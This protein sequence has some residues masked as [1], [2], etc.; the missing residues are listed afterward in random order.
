MGENLAGTERSDMPRYLAQSDFGTF[1]FQSGRIMAMFQSVGMT[2]YFQMSV[3]RGS[4]QL[5]IGA[6]PD[7]RSSAVMPQIPGARVVFSFPIAADIS[8]AV[9]VVE[10]NDGSGDALAASAMR[11][12]SSGGAGLLNCSWKWSFHLWSWSCFIAERCSVFGSQRW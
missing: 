1:P 3:K 6:P 4:S 12:G 2:Q 5:M 11:T 7:F 10:S 9:G 8:S